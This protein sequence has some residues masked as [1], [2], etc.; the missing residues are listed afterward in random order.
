MEVSKNWY[1]YDADGNHI[2]TIYGTESAV[3]QICE[4]EGYTYAP[5][6]D[7]NP[8]PVVPDPLTPE[9][10]DLLRQFDTLKLDIMALIQEH[11]WA[12]NRESFELV[13]R[14]YDAMVDY[15]I[16]LADR[17]RYEGLESYVTID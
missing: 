11:D 12:R 14:Q 5:V 17:I 8:N 15:Y 2:N 10:N 4:M 16:V 9:Q 6:P 1:I 3:K 13:A 7:E